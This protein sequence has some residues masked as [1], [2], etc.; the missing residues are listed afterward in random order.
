MFVDPRP[1]APGSLREVYRKYD[2]LTD[3]LPAMGYGQ[4]QI[5]ELEQT[6]RDAPCDLVLIATPIDLSRL[7]K[8]EKPALRVRYELKEHEPAVLSDAL[9][10]L[11]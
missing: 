4:T 5:S 7:M 1:Y 6:I 9:S 2:H 10:K 8:I 3:I 11:L